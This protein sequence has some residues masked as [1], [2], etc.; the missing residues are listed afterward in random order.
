M[1]NV[2]VIKQI[3]SGYRMECPD[4]CPKEIYQLMMDTWKDE[5]KDRPTFV[6]ISQ[7]L[8]NV[9]K[10][11]KQQKNQQLFHSNLNTNTNTSYDTVVIFK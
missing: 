9:Q 5:P 2:E 4:N 8:D 7:T 6:Q 11:Y 1:S 3:N 10:Q